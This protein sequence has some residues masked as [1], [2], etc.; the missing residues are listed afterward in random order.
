[1]IAD[2]G[3]QDVSFPQCE[4]AGLGKLCLQ[5]NC[6]SDCLAV[7]RSIVAVMT[8]RSGMDKIRSNRVCIAVAELFANILAHAYGGKAGRLDFETCIDVCDQGGYELSFDFRDYASVGW[9]GS[10]EESAAAETDVEN[11]CPGGL[12][13][14]LIY[15]VSDRCEHEVL[16]D[17][18]RWRLIFHLNEVNSDACARGE[19]RGESR[20]EA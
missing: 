10:V 9:L 5:F 8:A 1:M 6:S 12:G 16:E 18:N 2:H 13:L 11:L 14:K 7:L 15:S 20:G 3:V 17:G 19:N 4:R